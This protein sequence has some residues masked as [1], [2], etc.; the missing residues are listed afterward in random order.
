VEKEG[1]EV[2]LSEE[3]LQKGSNILCGESGET[4]EAL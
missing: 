4:A 3:M 1:K 2:I